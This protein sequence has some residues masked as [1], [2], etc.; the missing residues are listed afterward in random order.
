MND[1]VDKMWKN[2]VV[3]L[4]KRPFQNLK[5]ATTY[6]RIP[7]FIAGIETRDLPNTKQGCEQTEA[8][9]SFRIR[10]AKQFSVAVTI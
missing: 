5:I 4:C 7:G 9:H 2:V 3:A 1:D 8:R 10:L 6:L